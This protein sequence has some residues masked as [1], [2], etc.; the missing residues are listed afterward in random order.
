MEI[1][2]CYNAGPSGPRG[3]QYAS[4]SDCQNACFL[5]SINESSSISSRQLIKIVDFYG[6]EVNAIQE[7]QLLFYLYDDGTIEKKISIR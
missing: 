7:N 3:G 1:L 6:R 4:L 5:T 2:G